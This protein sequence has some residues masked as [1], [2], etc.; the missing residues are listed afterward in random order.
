MEQKGRLIRMYGIIKK[1]IERT[2]SGRK[3]S[4]NKRSGREC[5]EKIV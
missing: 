2:K 4:A 5:N 3:R 1:K